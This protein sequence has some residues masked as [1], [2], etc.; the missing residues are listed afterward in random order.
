MDRSTL[1]WTLLVYKIPSLPSRLRL[2]IW[3]R[4]QRMGAL[5]LQDAV[6]LLPARPDLQENMQYI[7]E[8]IAEMEGTYHLFSAKTMFEE[9]TEQLIRNFRQLAD[10]RYEEIGARIKSVE[11]SLEGAASLT[12]LEN[13]EEELKRE[14][15][16]Y[17]KTKRLSY[18]GSDIEREVENRLD[19]LRRAL[20]AIH[21]GSNK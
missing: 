6:C 4:L 19:T 20:D 8:A 13:A 1:E 7:G 10:M 17:L 5:Y 16:A 11:A 2:Q 12:D 3:R 9:G 15:I 18:F 21:R 14:R